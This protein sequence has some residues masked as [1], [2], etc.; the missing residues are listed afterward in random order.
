MYKNLKEN[1]S[2]NAGDIHSDAS[3][4]RPGTPAGPLLISGREILMDTM[5]FTYHSVRFCDLD[6]IR[7]K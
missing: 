5:G 4:G 6:L 7:D 3:T 1:M 2:K